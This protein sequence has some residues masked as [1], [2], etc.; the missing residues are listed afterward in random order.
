MFA[1]S[2]VIKALYNESAKRKKIS[3]ALADT[4]AI[5]YRLRLFCTAGTPVAQKE[6]FLKL[7]QDAELEKMHKQIYPGERNPDKYA[8]ISCYRFVI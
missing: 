2:D 3:E 1:S 4:E 5:E 8:R 7:A 6:E